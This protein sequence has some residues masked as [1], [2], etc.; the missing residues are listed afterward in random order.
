MDDVKQLF[1]GPSA[2]IREVMERI[3]TSAQQ[4]V[5]VV[6][7]EECLLGTVTDGD[8]RRALLKSS[9]LDEPVGGIMNRDPATATLADSREDILELMHSK[10]LHQIPILDERSRVVDIE[11]LDHVANPTTREN[12]VV[13]M[14]GGLGTRLRPITDE[15]PKSLVRIGERPVLEIIME[16][17]ISC[18]FRKFYLSV[19]YKAAMLQD[20][21]GNGRRWSVEIHYLEEKKRM[22]TAGAL[23]LLPETPTSPFVVM[24]GDLLTNVNFGQLLDFHRQH[25]AKATMCVKEYDF[26]VP[27]GVVNLQEHNI[28][29]VDEK[30]IHRFFVNA[31]IYVLEPLVLDLI[32]NDSYFDMPGLFD[33]ILEEKCQTV[34]F[35]IRE[36]WL[37]IG[38]VGDLEKANGDYHTMVGS[39]S[40]ESK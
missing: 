13:L 3:D 34:A 37:D 38:R 16:N 23:S 32:P 17:F 8:I 28:T 4:I 20:Y 30:P 2:T 9:P 11:I 35:P 29:S 25:H 27:F 5:L 39:P 14:V 21:F 31:G 22:G 12:W 33:R 1:V 40:H 18:G 10:R 26:Q 6:D 15:C 36:Y 19:G 24:N 7:E